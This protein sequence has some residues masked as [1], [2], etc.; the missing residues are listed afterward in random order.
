MQQVRQRVLVVDVGCDNHRAV[1]QPRATVHA[2]VHLHAEVPL[3][4]LARL[5]HLGVARLVGVLGRTRRADD[6]GVHDRA[7]AD[8][9]APCLQHLTHRGKQPLAESVL[10]QQ[11]AELQQGRAVGYPL[12]AQIDA[13]EASQRGAVQ[14]RLFAGLVCQVEPVLH[15]VHPQ[16]AFEADR[17][18]TVAGLGVVRLDHLAQRG[19][20]NNLVH[21]RQKHVPLGRATVLLETSALI[22]RCG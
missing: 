4:T 9:H 2:D 22:G 13:H 19:P 7:G 5:V 14:Q 11:A 15:E 10:L 17:W 16:H 6:G 12:S 21:R 3:P 1:S 8:L 20:R 18:T